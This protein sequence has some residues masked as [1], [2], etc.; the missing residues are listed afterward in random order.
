MT[1][2]SNSL[3]QKRI[4]NFVPVLRCDL[5]GGVNSRRGGATNEQRGLH[6]ATLHLAPDADHFGQRGRNETAQT[7]HV[8]FLF[9]GSVQNDLRGDHDAEIDHFVIVASE[10]DADNVLS[11]VVHVSFH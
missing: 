3:N 8:D 4:I 11:N 1:H 5:D 9:L 6:A 10:D 7:D 2:Y